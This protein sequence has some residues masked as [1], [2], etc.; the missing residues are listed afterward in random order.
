MNHNYNTQNMAPYLTNIPNEDIE[1]L[2]LP[3]GWEKGVDKY[4]RVYFIDHNTKTNTWNDP[5]KLFLTVSINTI[6]FYK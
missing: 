6:L 5:R 4:G 3:P 1:S 2:P